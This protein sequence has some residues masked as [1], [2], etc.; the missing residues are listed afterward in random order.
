MQKLLYY[1]FL[2]F[3]LPIYAQAQ[4]QRR[5]FNTETDFKPAR[6]SPRTVVDSLAQMEC[7]YTFFEMD[8]VLQQARSH[9]LILQ[10][11]GS[12]AR[13][14]GLK[15]YQ[16]D[17]V[18]ESCNYQITCG[19]AMGVADDFPVTYTKDIVRRLGTDVVRER[20]LIFLDWFEFTDSLPPLDWRMLEDTL[21]VCGHLCR[22]ATAGFRG[23]T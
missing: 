19:N 16:R 13:Q 8:C 6:F 1:L 18:F 4:Q 12:F 9:K 3:I 23:R 7:I 15:N 10:A 2:L 22:K 14:R 5:F 21:T 20:D 11:G 17:S